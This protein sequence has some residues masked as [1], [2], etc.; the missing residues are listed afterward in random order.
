MEKLA[1]NRCRPYLVDRAEQ[2]GMLPPAG[3]LQR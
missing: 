3:K 2:S 1:R